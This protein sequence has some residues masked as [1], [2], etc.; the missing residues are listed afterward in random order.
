MQ[1]RASR[2]SVPSPNDLQHHAPQHVDPR[3][4]TTVEAASALSISPKT[5]TKW[6]AQGRGPAHIP[7]G[8]R[9][10]YRDESLAAWISNEETGGGS[11]ARSKNLNPT[12]TVRAQ[13]SGKLQV[14]ILF[15]PPMKRRR[16]TAPPGLDEA[17]ASS[18]GTK[19]AKEL[20]QEF[21]KAKGAPQAEKEKHQ[22][23]PIIDTT[24]PTLREFWKTRFSA[25]YI[26]KQASNTR[27]DFDSAWRHHLG[28]ILGDFPLDLIG[29]AE[30]SKLQAHMLQLELCANTRNKIA[31]KIKKAIRCAV[32]WGVIP[33]NPL[34]L[35]DMK[36]EK[37]K[38]K[39][40]PIYTPDEMLAL[41]ETAKDMGEEHELCFLLLAHACLRI[42]ELNALQWEDLDLVAGTATIQSTI[43]QGELQDAP[44]GHT[45][46]IKL[47]AATVRALLRVKSWGGKRSPFV[48]PMWDK[49]KHCFTHRDQGHMIRSIQKQARL[50]VGG[51]HLMRHSTLSHLAKKGVSPYALKALARHEHM[52]TTMKYYIHLDETEL[53]GQAAAALEPRPPGKTRKRR[54]ALPLATVAIKTE[55]LHGSLN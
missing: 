7:L 31:G 11:R 4:M 46:T 12:I 35:E 32:S 26:A 55:S 23:T 36:K 29:K 20:W 8:S 25:E 18:W 10:A 3:L 54:L 34:P 14:D 43:A 2:R 6:R 5:L 24:T 42:G 39:K 22:P 33:K 17:S 50:R 13:P 47:T 28:P 49:T 41:H 30:I 53:S 21:T 15:K 38:K 52:A 37:I 19:R 16:L 27:V 1:Q 45:G 48:L 40:K 51:A 9:I 44:K